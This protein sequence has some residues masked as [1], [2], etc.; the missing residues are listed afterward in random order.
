MANLKNMPPYGDWPSRTL[1]AVGN[2]LTVR[3]ALDEYSKEVFSQSIPLA[4]PNCD[5]PIQADEVYRAGYELDNFRTIPAI[6]GR[7]KYCDHIKA[8]KW[9]DS[10]SISDWAPENAANST[11]IQPKPTA[12]R[13]TMAA[14]LICWL[15]IGA[16]FAI[17]LIWLK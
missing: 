5:Y 9:S 14:S 6:I 3:Q 10:E 16:I 13:N 17:L 7:G 12:L 1:D 15:I 2:R 8:I 11:E 4:C